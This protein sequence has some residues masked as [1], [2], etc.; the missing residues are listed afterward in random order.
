MKNGYLLLCGATNHA[1]YLD[2]G[3][4]A[5]QMLEFIDQNE[6]E[7]ISILNTHGHMD[8]ICGVR[9][10]KEEWDVPIY[11]HEEDEFLYKAL[12]QQ[13][14]WFGMSYP[15]PP[16]IDYYLS[17][18]QQLTLGDLSISVLHTPGHSPGSVSLIVEDHVFC[19]DL[20]FAGSVG[21]TDLPKGSMERLLQ[22]VREKILPLGDDYHLHPGHGPATTVG[23]EKAT[24]PYLQGSPGP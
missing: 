22:S 9:T 5:P 15:P 21:R 17:P 8:H 4:E 2:P 23:R 1:T 24:N 11:I 19:G 16:P 12:S 3:D 6:I 7:L 14:E 20:I 18:N 10:V 13:A